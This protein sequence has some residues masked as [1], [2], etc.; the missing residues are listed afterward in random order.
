MFVFTWDNDGTIRNQYM[1]ATK[2][3]DAVTQSF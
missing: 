3:R 2:F 1:S